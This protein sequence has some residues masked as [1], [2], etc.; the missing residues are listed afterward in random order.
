[1]NISPPRVLRISHSSVVSAWRR[2]EECLEA[3]GA[4]VTVVAARQ[5]H[6]GGADVKL[7]AL[8]GERIVRARTFGRHPCGFAYDPLAIWRALRSVPHEVLDIHEEPYSI[9]AIEIVLLR[10]LS[11]RHAPVVFYSAQNIPKHHPLPVRLA[12]RAV[13]AAAKGA[14]TCNQAAAAN[15]RRKSFRGTVR[16]IP[17]GVDP[18]ESGHG[19]RE[20]APARAAPHP[21]LRVGCAGRLVPEKGFATAI[22]AVADEP[23]WQLSIVGEGPERER[24]E[25]LATSLGAAERVKFVGHWR[26]D[27]MARFYASIDVLAVPSMPTPNWEEQFGRVAAEAMAAGVPVVSSTC[28]SLPE[29]VRDAGLL[30]SPGDVDGLRAA[31]ACVAEDS[32]LRRDLTR[33]GF[34]RARLYSWQK[35]AEEQLDLYGCVVTPKKASC[36]GRHYDGELP[37]VQV[38]VVAFGHPELLGATLSTLR[39]GSPGYHLP[40][41]V[42]DNSSDVSV[43]AV[44]Q[45]HGASYIRTGNN[46]GFSRAVNLAI[47]EHR[48]AGSDLLLLNPDAQVDG[49]T[50]LALQR[51]LHSES[52]LACVAP[53]Q[54][55][56]DGKDQRVAWPFPGPARAWAEAL[57]LGR[58]L[59]GA[60]FLIGSVLLI[61]G[62]ALEDVGNFDQSFFLYAEETDW[63]R[64][65]RSKGWGVRLCDDLHAIHLGGGTSSE[66]PVRREVLFAAGVE[67]YFRK[68]YGTR[69]WWVART[70]IVTGAL[71]RALLSQGARREATLRWAKLIA[72]GPVRRRE[73]LLRAP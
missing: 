29:V 25:K 53:S 2:R 26:D 4:T 30:F 46:L 15:L 64:R 41:V 24:L 7:E 55:S 5:W 32:S 65:A 10:W 59:S 68:W 21:S 52:R 62:A 23:G 45:D 11:G 51:R 71:A 14:Y 8:T 66:S 47:E 50:V 37:A 43:R 1:M 44:A 28:G 34:A 39:T 22:E 54:R 12:E 69:G 17:L 9:A 31:L 40:V 67:S 20:S 48:P 73:Q 38:V 49:A 6:E 19:P 18:P 27:E 42:V 56:P 36:T 13:L 72:L 60:D 61:N 33:K 3:L 57:G 70:A 58:F 35:V 16:T 63:Q